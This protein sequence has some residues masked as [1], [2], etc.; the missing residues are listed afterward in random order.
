MKTKIVIFATALIAAGLISSCAK[1]PVSPNNHPLVGM[2]ENSVDSVVAGFRAF[3]S[4]QSWSLKVDSSSTDTTASIDTVG[5]KVTSQRWLVKNTT[6]SASSDPQKFMEF[7]PTEGVLYPG[8][9]VQGNSIAG[10]ALSTLAV[11]RAGG[12]L[13]LDILSGTRSQYSVY[14]DSL[15]SSAV[16]QAMNTILYNYKGGFP[17][18]YA[19]TMEQVYSATQLNS[20]LDLGYS[21]PVNKIN[22][23]FNIDN[24]NSRSYVAVKLTQQFYTVS[25]NDPARPSDMIYKSVDP[26]ELYSELETTGPA[27]YISSVTYGRIYV[28]VYESTASASNL[29]AALDYA[30]NGT[31]VN[32]NVSSKTFFQNVMKQTTVSVMQIGGDAKQGLQVLNSQTGLNYDDIISFL[33]NGANFSST[34]VGL[35]ISYRVNYLV[36]DQLV[37]MNNVMQYTVSEKIPLDSS[38]SY[39]PSLFSI[40]I[41]RLNITS[42]SIKPNGGCRVVVG[43]TNNITGKDSI[44]WDCPLSNWTIHSYPVYDGSGG[45]YDFTGLPAMSVGTNYALNWTVPQITLPNN[46]EYKLWIDFGINTYNS[47]ENRRN[48][49][50][51]RAI[52]QYDPMSQEWKFIK[53]EDNYPNPTFMTY[54]TNN[55][56]VSGR[57]VYG[58]NEDGEPLQP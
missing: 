53:G 57:F 15:C 39:L 5:Q 14:V 58:I 22:A 10:G 54:V 23:Q 48:W 37:A 8:N 55:P 11:P 41:N 33:T 20:D 13:T 18:Q 12:Y 52:L 42:T 31:L 38:S 51:A 25:V 4:P 6:Y 32:G 21:G 26:R 36:N 30:Y 28:L 27:C 3:N 45:W 2:I 19:Y 44:I 49:G 50:W 24:S 17:A 47:S 1:N 7:S 29:E 34:N 46:T 35:P 16:N 40:F 43:L 9:L 56:D